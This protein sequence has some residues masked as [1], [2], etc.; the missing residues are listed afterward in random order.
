[1]GMIKTSL[2]L[3]CLFV[4]AAGTAVSEEGTIAAIRDVSPQQ[5]MQQSGKLVVLDVRTP[6]EFKAGHIPNAVNLDVTAKSFGTDIKALDPSQTYLVHCGANAP[7]GRAQ[8]ALQQLQQ[9]GF[10][11][12]ENLEGG[13]AGWVKA[14]G[15]VNTFSASD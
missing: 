14:G 9:A 3:T 11:H 10:T 2:V 13:Y 8:N 7:D 1:M 5:A 4:L 12:L 6:Q 15:N